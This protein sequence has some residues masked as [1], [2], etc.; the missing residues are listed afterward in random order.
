MPPLPASARA[1]S[2][3]AVSPRSWSL[4]VP[5]SETAAAG[6]GRKA[7]G[8]Q[9]EDLAAAH[10]ES[11]GW[12]IVARNW[13]SHGHGHRGEIDIVARD[14]D[15]LVF[16][17]VRTRRAAAN[18]AIPNLG[19]PEDSVTPRKQLQLAQIAYAYLY[20]FPWRGPWRI[21]VVAL[22]LTRDGATARFAHYRD[23]VGG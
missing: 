5:K 19:R 3:V 21:D 7:L 14:G 22:E 17:E 12:Q 9:G 18:G 8:R 16:V 10:L 13:Q 4:V 2:I 1:P 15:Y 11:A 6:D 23:A 20:D